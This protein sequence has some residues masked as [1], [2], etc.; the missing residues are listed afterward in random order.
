MPRTLQLILRITGLTLIVI[1]GI[2]FVIGVMRTMQTEEHSTADGGFV[3]Q[4]RIEISRIT[5]AIGLGGA[6]VFGLSFIRTQ[7]TT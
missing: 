4:H 5:S 7:W 1:A 2:L 6:V 3:I